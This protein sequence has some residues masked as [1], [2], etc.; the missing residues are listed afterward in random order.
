MKQALPARARG[1]P[2]EVW[3]QDEARI[4][5]KGTLTRIWAGL[6]SRP[7]GPRDSRY[8]WAYIFAAVCSERATGAALVMPYANTEA[9]NLHLQEISRAVAPG[10]HA[11]L[12]FDGA[13]WHTSPAL[14]PPDNIT[15]IRLPP[16]APELNPNENIWEYM[17]KNYLALRVVDDYDAIVE[18]CC[19]AWN[20]LLAMPDRLASITRRNCANVS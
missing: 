7:R 16:Y 11:A 4:G 8:K 17:R 9:M 20:D 10:A 12:V 6:G 5:Q 18:A 2:L 3:F 19:K 13:G 1:K 14:E 15:P